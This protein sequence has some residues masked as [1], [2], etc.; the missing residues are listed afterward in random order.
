MA[1]KESPSFSPSIL[2]N[3][4][5][6]IDF[7]FLL[8]RRALLNFSSAWILDHCSSD[9]IDPGIGVAARILSSVQYSSAASLSAT[10]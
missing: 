8:F 3:A 6:T 4:S 2:G 10:Q 7:C 9:M 5:V 1:G